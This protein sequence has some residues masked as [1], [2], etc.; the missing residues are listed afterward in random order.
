MKKFIIFLGL[1]SLAFSKTS[2]LNASSKEVLLH[3]LQ[4]Q[5]KLAPLSGVFVQ[6]NKNISIDGIIMMV[7]CKKQIIINGKEIIKKDKK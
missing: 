7:D 2:I 1:I 6:C 4:K 3:T 5:I